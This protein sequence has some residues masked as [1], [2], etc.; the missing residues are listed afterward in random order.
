MSKMQQELLL[1]QV[2]GIKD[3]QVSSYAFELAKGKREAEL[4]KGGS[5]KKRLSAPEM[6]VLTVQVEW[7]TDPKMKQDFKIQC[8]SSSHINYKEKLTNKNDNKRLICLSVH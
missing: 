3:T 7:Y 1:G 4:I 6:C 2:E 8:H 5:S